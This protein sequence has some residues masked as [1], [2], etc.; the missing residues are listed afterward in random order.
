MATQGFLPRTLLIAAALAAPAAHGTTNY[1]LLAGVSHTDNL[2]RDD[3]NGVGEEIAILGARLNLSGESRRYNG[4]LRG[5]V[6]YQRFVSGAFDSETRPD[7]HGFYEFQF[8]PD[9]FSWVFEDRFGQ[10]VTDPFGA[11]TLANRELMN[12]FV[13]GPNLKL[14]FFDT[15]SLDIVARYTDTRFEVS[16]SDNQR[17]SAD[18]GLTRALSRHR[19][20]SVHATSENVRFDL[21]VYPDFDRRSAYFQFDSRISRGTL[22]ARLGTNE[23]AYEFDTFDGPLIKFDLRYELTS[24]LRLNIGFDRNISDASDQFGLSTVDGTAA[25][26]HQSITPIAD[27]FETEQASLGIAQEKQQSSFNLGYY[28]AQDRYATETY[29]DATRSGISM[30]YGYALSSGWKFDIS[31]FFERR[32]FDNVVRE[33]DTYEVT[34]GLRRSL[35]RTLSLT[36]EYLR[37]DRSS[38]D[39]TDTYI[40][41]R[42]SLSMSY[43]PRSAP[44]PE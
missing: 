28:Y 5:N 7:L 29:L 14:G 37:A 3:N 13:T 32:D 27:T 4:F 1:E 44:I 42:Y 18:I 22:L 6:T 21:P 34:V 9:S 41:N 11:D 35:T 25:T 36:L 39:M 12:R 10:V 40:E 38:Q 30:G 23:V 31:G 43:R 33:D 17:I 2:L 19:S 8:I 20:I 16:D 24:T 15:N 26:V